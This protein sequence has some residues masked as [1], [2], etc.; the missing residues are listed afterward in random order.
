MSRFFKAVGVD[1]I[2]IDETQGIEVMLDTVPDEYGLAAHL[3][4]M[5]PDL[6]NSGSVCEPA[7]LDSM[8]LI[9]ASSDGH[10]R[11]Y[12]RIE[13]DLAV[14]I[15]Y[16]HFTNNTGKVCLIH[17]AVNRHEKSKFIRTE[18]KQIFS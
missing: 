15:D 16:T 18:T 7:L 14:F 12:Q 17:F 2:N 6:T 10:F 4:Q 1:A 13:Q 9:Q 11:I 8:D 3:L 5:L